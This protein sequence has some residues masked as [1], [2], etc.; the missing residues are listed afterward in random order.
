MVSLRI[1]R[2]YRETPHPAPGILWAS[3][4]AF[5][6]DD[7]YLRGS[8]RLGKVF[9]GEELTAPLDDPHSDRIHIGIQHVRAMVG[10][11]EKLRLNRPRCRTLSHIFR[12]PDKPP[13]RLR[14]S[15]RQ[16]RLS[17]KPMRR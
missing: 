7:D 14:N 12:Q 9:D 4:R 17:G 5:G 10:G 2:K 8:L 11:F 15:R 13:S 3:A 6:F 1:R 16:T